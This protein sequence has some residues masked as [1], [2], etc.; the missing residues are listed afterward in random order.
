MAGG[1]LLRLVMRFHAHTFA[2]FFRIRLWLSIDQRIHLVSLFLLSLVLHKYLALYLLL[3]LFR[4]HIPRYHLRRILAYASR[5]YHQR[6]LI[7]I[8]LGNLQNLESIQHRCISRNSPKAHNVASRGGR[9][10]A[11][12]VQPSPEGDGRACLAWLWLTRSGP[13]TSTLPATA[14]LATARILRGKNTALSSTYFYLNGTPPYCSG[15]AYFTE[16]KRTL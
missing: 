5:S 2:T 14:W 16:P 13:T 15:I 12:D 8:D 4:M 1:Q 9:R 7:L 10:V 3:N 6:F 11:L